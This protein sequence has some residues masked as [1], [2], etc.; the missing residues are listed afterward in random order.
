MRAKANANT[1]GCLYMCVRLRYSKSLSSDG[2]T[3]HQAAWVQAALWNR[4]TQRSRVPATVCLLD[5]PDLL[6]FGGNLL[7]TQRGKRTF[8]TTFNHLRKWGTS[9]FSHASL[10]V[11]ADF[12]PHG[13]VLLQHWC[14]TKAA[15]VV[16]QLLEDIRTRLKGNL[17]LKSDNDPCLGRL[18]SRRSRCGQVQTWNP[19]ELLGSVDRSHEV[20]TLK[21]QLWPTSS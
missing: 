20:W 11:V 1:C 9:F 10:P 14:D 13:H 2:A 6:H 15:L 8:C 3:S 7:A 17:T 5:D 21:R 12:E 19:L 4:R 18:L 16:A